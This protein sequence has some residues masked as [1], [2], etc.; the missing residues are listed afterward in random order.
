VAP[1]EKPRARALVAEAVEAGGYGGRVLL[2][3]INGL[4]TDWGEADLVA[5]CAA[6]PDGILLPK[7]EG[8]EDLARAA[9]LMAAHGAPEGCRLWAMM[10]TPR[11]ILNAA[12]IAGGHPRLAGLVLGTN[13]LVKEL[14]A[15]HTP[16]R[17][18][19]VASLG[20]CL[21]AARAEGLVCVDGVF[22]AFQDEDGL[23]AACAQ[24]RASSALA[25][26]A[27]RRARVAARTRSE[28]DGTI[29]LLC[30]AGSGLSWRKFRSQLRTQP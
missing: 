9:A 23:R 25:I 15:E 2:V 21:L 13:D 12:A 24:G 16:D 10:E 22:N 28:S 6:G 14:G 26:G 5:A 20:L 18:A 29:L 17:L 27:A 11:G 7:V 3:R 30:L 4:G 19:L 8:P 1:A